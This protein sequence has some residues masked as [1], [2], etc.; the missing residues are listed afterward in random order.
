MVRSRSKDCF[1][2][3]FNTERIMP[4][5]KLSNAIIPSVMETTKV[6]IWGTRPVMIKVS[7]TGMKQQIAAIKK[8]NA[9][10]LKKARDLVSRNRVAMVFNTRSPSE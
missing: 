10:M 9:I 1:S 5:K 6:G 3:F 4:V 8:I 2:C 7:S